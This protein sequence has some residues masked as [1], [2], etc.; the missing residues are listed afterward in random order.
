MKGEGE[1]ENISFAWACQLI[2]GEGIIKTENWYFT[3]N[4]VTTDW[5]ENRV[6]THGHKSSGWKT[7]GG[8]V[9]SL[10]VSPPK[11]SLIRKVRGH[12]TTEGAN[13]RHHDHV[14]GVTSPV[15][16]GWCT[17]RRRCPPSKP[18]TWMSLC[19]RPQ[20]EGH[21]QSNQLGLFKDADDIKDTSQETVLDLRGLKRCNI[22]IQYGI[23]DWILNW[24]TGEAIPAH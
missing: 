1:K 7:R 18:A 8:S 17:H 19:S 12:F 9:Q 13:G 5:G 6:Q 2:N 20:T 11:Q 16:Q 21:L 24:G 3:A 10:K 15:M 22:Q 14:A 23:P 4:T